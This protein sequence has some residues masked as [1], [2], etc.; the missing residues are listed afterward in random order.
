MAASSVKPK[1]LAAGFA[2]ISS[3]VWVCAASGVRWAS[4]AS[5]ALV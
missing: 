1:M 2:W 3:Y 4:S 5:T